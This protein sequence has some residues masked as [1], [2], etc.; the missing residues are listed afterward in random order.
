MVAND[1]IREK[2]M[3]RAQASELVKIGKAAGLR[4]I[5]EDGW[6]KVQDGITTVEEVMRVTQEF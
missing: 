2:I 5:R 3:V 1:A 4:L 6:L